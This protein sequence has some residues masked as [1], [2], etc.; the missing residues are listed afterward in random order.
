MRSVGFVRR[1]TKHKVRFTSIGFLGALTALSALSSVPAAADTRTVT[2]GQGE[3]TRF[4]IAEVS[5]HHYQRIDGAWRLRHTIRTYDGWRSRELAGSSFSI[6]LRRTDRY[7]NIYFK[8]G[9][10]ARVYKTNPETHE[11]RI[12]GRPPVWREGTRTVVV[13]LKRRLLGRIEG[14]YG[15]FA[16]SVWAPRCRERNAACPAYV[17]RAPDDGYIRHNL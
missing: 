5:H 9:L 7:V 15:W 13:S 6:Q 17:D 1:G 4:D 11:R 16:S 12:V 14:G 8:H 3:M 10:K 2:D